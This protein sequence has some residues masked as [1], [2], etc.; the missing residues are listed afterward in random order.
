M[1]SEETKSIKC[2][3]IVLKKKDPI[4]PDKSLI[5]LDIQQIYELI[6]KVQ[7]KKITLMKLN[8]DFYEQFLTVS[9]AQQIYELL[10][11]E[12]KWST[13]ISQGRR[14]NQTYGDYGLTYEIKFGGYGNKPEKI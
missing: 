1:N 10:E 5:K 3:K 13:S 7:C 4:S 11:K 12:V 14:S 8:I 9:D 6:E 2:K